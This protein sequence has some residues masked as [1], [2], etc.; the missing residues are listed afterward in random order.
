MKKLVVSFTC[1]VF[2]FGLYT[3]LSPGLDAAPCNG[4]GKKVAKGATNCNKCVVP[5]GCTIFECSSSCGCAL[6]CPQGIVF[7]PYSAEAPAEATAERNAVR[8]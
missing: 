6:N 1:A 8:Y 2:A 4:N 5:E 3:L 7:T